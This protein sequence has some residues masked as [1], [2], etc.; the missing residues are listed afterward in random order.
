MTAALRVVRAG[1][2]LASITLTA[3]SGYLV[4]LTPHHRE[5]FSWPPART[6]TWPRTSEAQFKTL[7]YCSAFPG[8]ASHRRCKS[9]VGVG[10]FKSYQL[11]K[12]TYTRAIT[13][14]AH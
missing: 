10:S 1:S 11:T 8:V 6:F 13:S 3:R 12:E 2:D 5:D 14:I 4:D 7:K 9:G